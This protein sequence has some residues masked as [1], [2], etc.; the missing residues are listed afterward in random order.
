MPMRMMRNLKLHAVGQEA[1]LP[2]DDFDVE[3]EL[4][5]SQDSTSSDATSS[6]RRRKLPVWAQD[7]EI[8]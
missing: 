2:N 3:V 6:T 5:A 8:G 4:G 7:Y 1:G